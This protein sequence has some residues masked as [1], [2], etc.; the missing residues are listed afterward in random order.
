MADMEVQI[1]RINP[2]AKMPVLAYEGDAGMDIFSTEEL[3]IP[4][5]EKAVIKTGLKL[6]IP[7]GYAGF[8]WDKSGLA[9]K[10]HL[11]TMAGV[12]DSNYRGE[13]MVVLTNMGKE[14]Y[15]VEKGSKIA[16]LVIAPVASLEIVE[17]DI[18][19]ETDRGEGGFGSSGSK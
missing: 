9:L 1:Q 4:P 7:K 8:V 16:Q 15:H 18:Q 19:D 3:E 17:A 13:F 5:G 12:I 14:T 11:K 6:A 10:H 2:E